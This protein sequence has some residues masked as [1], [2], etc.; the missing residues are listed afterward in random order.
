MKVLDLVYLPIDSLRTR[1]QEL[2]LSDQKASWLFGHEDWEHYAQAYAERFGNADCSSCSV[3]GLIDALRNRQIEKLCLVRGVNGFDYLFRSVESGDIGDVYLVYGSCKQNQPDDLSHEE[4]EKHI[5]TVSI[6]ANV[7]I[8]IADDA[9]GY[10]LLNC[11]HV[12]SLHKL[13]SIF[14]N[15]ERYYSLKKR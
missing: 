2:N 12:L 8:D 9:D 1:V 4:R 7:I 6:K 3:Y 14:Y 10:T 15:I 11:I 5:V 13:Q